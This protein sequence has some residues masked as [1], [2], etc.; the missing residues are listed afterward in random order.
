MNPMTRL[1]SVLCAALCAALAPSGA[2]AGTLRTAAGA[3]HEG[4]LALTP[5]G[6]VVVTRAGAP[7]VRVPLADVA[8][9][10]FDVPPPP[11]GSGTGLR[12]EYFAGQEFT[13][14]LMLRIDGPI[15]FKWNQEPPHPAL[16]KENYCVRWTGRIEPR[17]TEQYSFETEADDG[18]RLW[19]DGRLLMENWKTRRVGRDRCKIALEA[20]RRYDLKLEYFQGKND[21]EIRLYW[22]SL[23]GQAPEIV[24]AECLFLPGPWPEGIVTRSGS[25][26]AGRPGVS[27]EGKITVTGAAGEIPLGRDAAA[28]VVFADLPAGWEDGI[29]PGAQGVLLANGDFVEGEIKSIEAGAVTLV[30]R[31][32]GV[33]RYDGGV[34]APAVALA[35]PAPAETPWEVRFSEGTTVRAAELKMDGDAL[36]AVEPSAGALR[37]PAA[38]VERLRKR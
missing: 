10:V 29:P 18:V 32:F 12:G 37:F 19:I 22:A 26:L 3:V 14:R 27:P 8:E 17:Y 21:A 30:S 34:D 25:F 31:L 7:E 24:P 15:Q 16:P 28:R 9:A 13:H 23:S 20:G 4:A 6:A 33:R 2:G 35:D 5:D 36:V 11:S 1:A 38:W